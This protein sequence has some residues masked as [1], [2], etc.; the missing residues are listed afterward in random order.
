MR[1]SIAILFSF[2]LLSCGN[3]ALHVNG[4]YYAILPGETIEL[5]TTTN[6]CCYYCV[7]NQ[8]S[9]KSVRFVD[10]KVVEEAPD[11]CDGC[12]STDAWTFKGIKVG[13]DTIILKKVGGG[14]QC[15]DPAY[16]TE[17]YVV[18]VTDK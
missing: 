10:R 12:S 14:K 2:C 7:P 6:S 9:L 3:N 18:I 4:S 17:R 8:D 13:I 16:E 1:I 11:D 15:S 5:Y